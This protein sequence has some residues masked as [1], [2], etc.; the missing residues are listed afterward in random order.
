MSKFWGDRF[1]REKFHNDLTRAEMN[2]ITAS[3][4]KFVHDMRKLEKSN[5]DLREMGLPV[6]EP[7]AK[8]LNF[9]DRLARGDSH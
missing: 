7:N 8:Q 6:W 9:L 1:Q 2:A 4:T 5:A 3:A